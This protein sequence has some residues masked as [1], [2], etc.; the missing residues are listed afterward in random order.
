M[1][2]QG[3]RINVEVKKTRDDQ[4]SHGN[5]RR[6]MRGGNGNRGG[7]FGGGPRDDMNNRGGEHGRYNNSN[8][9]N[10]PAHRR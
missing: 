2:Y 9:S 3:Q 5:Q 4:R 7:G 1:E 8:R 10:A 6:H